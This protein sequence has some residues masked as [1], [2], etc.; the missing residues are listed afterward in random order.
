MKNII[1]IENIAVS[2]YE[3]P[4]CQDLFTQLGAQVT[5]ATPLM[6]VYTL[7]V[8][9]GVPFYHIVMP[10]PSNSVRSRIII[11]SASENFPIGSSQT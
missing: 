4:F 10:L 11:D 9:C 6:K 2:R 1:C 3:A 7:R 5:L 8:V